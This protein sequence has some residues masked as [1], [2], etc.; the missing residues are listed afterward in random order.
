MVRL[1]EAVAL[2]LDGENRKSTLI[3][4]IPKVVIFQNGTAARRVVVAVSVVA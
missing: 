2:R 3:L 4:D 1:A